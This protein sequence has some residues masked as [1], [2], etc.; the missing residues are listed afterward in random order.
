MN[1]FAVLRDDDIGSDSGHLSPQY[2]MQEVLDQAGAPGNKVA[3]PGLT[4][5]RNAYTANP[6]EPE[7]STFTPPKSE[8]NSTLFLAN[9][10]KVERKRTGRTQ[11]TRTGKGLGGQSERDIDELGPCWFYQDPTG[12]IMGPYPS[13]RMKEWLDRRMIESSLLI[14]QAGTDSPFQPISVV[15]PE[16]G[17][18]FADTHVKAADTE[19][20]LTTLVS[21]SVTEE[22]SWDTVET[23]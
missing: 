20:Q 8:I 21:F 5:F 9:T 19:K 18:A 16:I 3:P 6:Q 23:K 2:T 14:R 15:F 10:G 12:R 17:S 1:N 22:G 7:C 11:S 13:Q 4:K